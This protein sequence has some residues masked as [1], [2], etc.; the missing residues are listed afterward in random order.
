MAVGFDA[1]EALDSL[2]ILYKQE[3]LTSL[4]HDVLMT[5]DVLKA[6]SI[7]DITLL[8]KLWDDEYDVCK[9]ELLSRTPILLDIQF[10]RNDI[11]LITFIL[12]NYRTF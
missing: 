6:A 7:T 10:R 1:V 5:S 4:I 11:F 2:W 9:Q 3:K 8:T 12:I